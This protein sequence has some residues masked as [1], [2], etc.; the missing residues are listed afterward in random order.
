M[1]LTRRDALAALASAGVVAGAGATLEAPTAGED[2]LDEATLATL[3][4]VA[5]VVYPTAVS[6]VAAF[7][8]RYVGPR[9]AARPAWA[10]GVAESA[11]Y[12]EAYAR[13]WRDADFAALEADTRDAVLRSMGADA[14]APAPDGSDAE[15]VR[16]Y[17]V[18]DLLFALYAS[19]TG[20]RLVG[21]ENPQ[22]HPG[23]TTSYRRPGER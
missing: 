9:A 15:R 16:H 8:E 7:V 10:E 6:G 4:A 21:I 23:G 5:E 2:G 14:A 19:P 1:R 3:T 22:G 12:L 11:A 20:G 13:S 18:N 17:L